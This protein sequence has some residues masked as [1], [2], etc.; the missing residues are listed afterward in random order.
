M[1]MYLLLGETETLTETLTVLSSLSLSVNFVVSIA[2]Q[3][4]SKDAK[5]PLNTMTKK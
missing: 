4:V 3:R 5:M 1:G 2:R